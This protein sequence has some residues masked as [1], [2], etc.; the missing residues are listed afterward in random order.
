MTRRKLSFLSLLVLLLATC[1][2]SQALPV[3]N[4]LMRQVWTCVLPMDAQIGQVVDSLATEH[5]ASQLVI[6]AFTAYYGPQWFDRYVGSDL[7]TRFNHMYGDYLAQN[8][9][10][11]AVM[12]GLSVGQGEVV[13][14]P[15]K[16]LAD[17]GTFHVFDV[18]V[19][20][21]STGGWTLVALGN[22]R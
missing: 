17:D 20:S 14:I 18:V 6:E 1:A 5:P 8:L 22:M 10:F 7:K 12:V 9:P 13:S 2:V 11:M 16:A 19:E 21:S 3:Q 4:A 15:V